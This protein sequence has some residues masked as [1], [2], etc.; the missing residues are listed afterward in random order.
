MRNTKEYWDW[1]NSQDDLLILIEKS[2]NKS[3][4]IIMNKKELIEKIEW[5]IEGADV[6]DNIFKIVQDINKLIKEQKQ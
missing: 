3:K 1:N 6:G 4:A 5:I 2:K